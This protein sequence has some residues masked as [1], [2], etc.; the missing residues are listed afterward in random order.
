MGK[1]FAFCAGLLA[2]V[3]DSLAQ[4]ADLRSVVKAPPVITAAYAWG[5]FYIGAHGGASWGEN[6][7]VD[8]I[9]GGDAARF[10]AHGYFGGGQIGY[11]WQSGAWVFGGEL[12]GTL[13]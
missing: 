3:I 5:G 4:A 7:F 10:T 11:N 2:L 9:G 13:S 1:A 8:L 6:D 12:E